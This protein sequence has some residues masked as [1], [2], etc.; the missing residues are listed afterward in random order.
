MISLFSLSRN[1]NRKF[2][3]IL[4]RLFGNGNDPEPTVTRSD[5]LIEQENAQQEGKADVQTSKKPSLREVIGESVNQ[6]LTDTENNNKRVIGSS[7][8]DQK[9]PASDGRPNFYY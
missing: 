9:P 5:S 3:G 6:V 8:F 1:S 4:E 2:L 7:T